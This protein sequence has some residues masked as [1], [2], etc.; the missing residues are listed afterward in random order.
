MEGSPTAK[1]RRSSIGP[2]VPPIRAPALDAS[3]SD[4]RAAYERLS[5]SVND[6]LGDFQMY[7]SH[8]RNELCSERERLADRARKLDLLQ[9]R[10]HLFTATAADPEVVVDVGGERFPTTRGTLCAVQDTL[11]SVM[12]AGDFEVEKNPDGSVRFDRDPE[13]F[14][15]VLNFL[16]DRREGRGAFNLKGLSQAEASRLATEAEFYGL[17]ELKRLAINCTARVVSQEVDAQYRSVGAALADSKDGDRIVVFPGTYFES[18]ET[19]K[20]VEVCGEGPREKITIITSDDAPTFSFSG[21]GGGVLRNLSLREMSPYGSRAVEI[22][23]NAS[24]LVENCDLATRQNGDAIAVL[25]HGSLTL[26]ECRIHGVKGSAVFLRD[27]STA[28]I[29]GNLMHDLMS[30]GV[31]IRHRSR[32][33]VQDNTVRRACL[34]GVDV[35]DD[36]TGT[37]DGNTIQDCARGGIVMYGRSHTLI[38]NN[39]VS[40]CEYGLRSFEASQVVLKNNQ[41]QQSRIEDTQGAALRRALA[42]EEAHAVG[43]DGA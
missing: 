8:V 33:Y 22:R 7:E 42:E 40:R 32:F 10:L 23:E 13:P 29:Q 18:I 39:M 9:H 38:K 16:R 26:R 37:I 4:L 3:F 21:T 25:D 12:L 5:R 28:T 24:L 14:K 6:A 17:D 34:G 43:A 30:C 2:R 11:F 31:F 41:V 20:R 19:S 1:R 36:S 27:D 15:Y 35:N